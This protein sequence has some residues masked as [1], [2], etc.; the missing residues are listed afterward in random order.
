MFVLPPVANPGDT[1][2]DNGGPAVDPTAGDS[3]RDLNAADFL[4]VADN[5]DQLA[6]R[7]RGRVD[8]HGPYHATTDGLTGEIVLQADDLLSLAA[9]MTNEAFINVL[10]RVATLPGGS[11]SRVMTE[12]S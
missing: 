12:P 7:L 10:N 8:A 5:L 2:P 6:G 9:C 3:D 11:N 1:S 4:D